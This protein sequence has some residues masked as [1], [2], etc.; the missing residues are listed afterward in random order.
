[1]A[2][3]TCARPAA[4]QRP[5]AGQ[6]T[7]APGKD[8]RGG[9]DRGRGPGKAPPAAA[10]MVLPNR[11]NGVTKPHQWRYQTRFAE[12]PDRADL[13]GR[14]RMRARA[15]PRPRNPVTQIIRAGLGLGPNRT[16]TLANTLFQRVEDPR[17]DRP[18]GGGRLR[19]RNRAA[20]EIPIRPGNRPAE[21]TPRFF[22]SK[23]RVYGAG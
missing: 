6:G 17:A 3:P 7:K 21:G 22:K 9:K 20:R 2:L 11:I 4:N 12:G 19:K 13:K 23:G 10:S 5:G 18:P 14:G 8:H 1:M 16:G 15:R